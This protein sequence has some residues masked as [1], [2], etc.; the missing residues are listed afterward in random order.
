V[1][2]L[3]KK[4]T[5]LNLFIDA[6]VYLYLIG[7]VCS[8]AVL[9][10]AMIGFVATAIF[11]WIRKA[12]KSFSGLS[13]FLFPIIIFIITLLT[14][15]NSSD[16]AVLFDFIM[17]KLPFLILPFAFFSVKERIA[18]RY[19]HYL[20]AFVFIVT[21]VSLGVLGNYLMNFEQLNDA[22]GRGQAITTP[23]DHTEFSIYVGFAAIVSILLNLE[24]KKIVSF[25]TKTSLGYI[26]IFLIIFMHILAVRS[27]LAVFYA[28]AL[29]FGLYYFIKNRQYKLLIGFL[30]AAMLFPIVAV[31][32]IPSL[33]TKFDYF[34]W[35]LSRYKKGEGVNLS[36]SQRI[37]SLRA[38]LE[39]FRHNPVLGIG[40]G[41]L[42]AECNKKYI[43]YVGKPLD[44]YPH[45][46]YLFV[47][48]S[49]GIIGFIF[50]LFALLGPVVA[51][52]RT[53]DPYFL[54]LYGVVLISALVENTLERT[55]SIGFYLFF[56]L[57]CI[58]YLTKPWAQQK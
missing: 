20:T 36:D 23:I 31:K 21:V 28:V 45:N 16:K 11:C 2:S 6:W 29:V 5:D 43:E 18:E 53:L 37:Y 17:K 34:R 4:Q 52:R 27:G 50:Y 47:L 48:A 35:D 14:G 24:K 46:Q 56:V 13:P 22:I 3:D 39:I 8:K 32:T 55:F 58:C 40:V 57:T 1:P 51:L 9:S 7:L 10:I 12:E 30:I 26:T 38:G 19:Y 42:K 33:K 44:H 41:D 49:M 25:G 15:N 54:T